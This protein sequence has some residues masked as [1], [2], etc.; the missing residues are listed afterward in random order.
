[1]SKMLPGLRFQ[2]YDS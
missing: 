1:M 2:A